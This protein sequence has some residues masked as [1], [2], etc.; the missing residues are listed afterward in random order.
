M[1]F[2][3]TLARI[4][5]VVIVSKQLVVDDDVVCIVII[6]YLCSSDCDT[7]MLYPS[8]VY[9]LCNQNCILL[10]CLKTRKGDTTTFKN[11]K[12]G[13]HWPNSSSKTVH[14]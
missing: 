7:D 12:K 1:N 8:N 13:F 5:G 3:V 14:N 6:I 10:N 11:E 9:R 2:N 4:C